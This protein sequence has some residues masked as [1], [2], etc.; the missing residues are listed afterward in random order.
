MFSAPWWI[1][2]TTLPTVWII[3][4]DAERIRFVLGA[5]LMLLRPVSNLASTRQTALVF[6]GSQ[7]RQN[8]S[9]A[10]VQPSPR[11]CPRSPHQ[12]AERA[13]AAESEGI[14]CI[15]RTRTSVECPSGSR[16]LCGNSCAGTGHPIG[17]SQSDCSMF[18]RFMAVDRNCKDRWAA[19]TSERR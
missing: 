1:A 9:R 19:S 3:L 8:R 18:A 2:A 11:S 15:V 13:T 12:E 16:C 14:Q 5:D 7:A 4:V 10:P 17:S 6:P